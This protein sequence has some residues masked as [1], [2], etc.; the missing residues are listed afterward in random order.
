MLKAIT[1]VHKGALEIAVESIRSF[2]HFFSHS[3]ELTIHI[4]SSIGPREKTL[5]LQ[6]AN[7]GKVKIVTPA[8]R[9]EKLDKY[10]TAFPKTR[11]FLDGTSY[12]TKLEIPI[13]EKAPYFYFD[14]DVI[15][16]KSAKTFKP[17]NATNAFSTE[18]WSSY[19]GIAKPRLWIQAKTPRRVNSGLQYIGQE[20][21][22]QKMEN[23]LTRNMF[24]KNLRYAGDQEL[25]AY[26]YND[27]EYYH[28][29]DFKRS[30]VG[31][32]YELEKESC[33]ALHFVGKMWQSHI[34]QINT[35]SNSK[36]KKSIDVRLLPSVPFSRFEFFRMKLQIK[37]GESKLLAKPLN[38][39]RKLLRTY[40]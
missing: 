38:I 13:F 37:M 7:G 30:R 26:L 15:W 29:S 34:D 19:Q 20:F 10:L 14:S 24:N 35:I 27:L 4:D 32:K 11:A 40:R 12:F 6:A 22:F 31:S 1:L 17:Q 33:A 2:I 25:Y 21:P 16:L 8:E 5:L 36:D 3:H 18:T 39:F 28:P 23:L 9:K